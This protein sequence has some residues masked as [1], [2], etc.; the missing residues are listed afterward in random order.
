MTQNFGNK[1]EAI[2]DLTKHVLKPKQYIELYKII[3]IFFVIKYGYRCLHFIAL[4]VTP[5]SGIK[6]LRLITDL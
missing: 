4:L 5:L 1:S 3:F 6:K 2:I